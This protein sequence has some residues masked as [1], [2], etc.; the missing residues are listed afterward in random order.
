VQEPRFRTMSQ[1][2]V[3]RAEL[4]P[5]I[6][7]VMR[8]RTKHEWIGLLEAANVPC[9]PINNMKEV[10]EDPQVLHRGLRVDIPH[11]SGGKA[12]VVRSPLRLSETPVEYRLAPP[13]LG[14]HNQE[15]L[16][17]L[18]GRSAAELATLKAAGI[19]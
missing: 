8:T 15:I 17:G 14:Q 18:L 16:Q 2:I 19:I 3:H 13:T 11:P 6:A 12:A 1:R 9:G 4:I 5:L 7:D 10:F